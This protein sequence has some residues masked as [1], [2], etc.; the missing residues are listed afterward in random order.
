MASE[1]NG[2]ATAR[3]EG[4]SAVFAVLRQLLRPYE[5]EL[6]IRIDKPGNCYLETHSSSMNGRPMF[7]AGRKNQ[8]KLRQF[9]S[10]RLIY[11]SR[12]GRSNFPFSEEN[13]AGTGLL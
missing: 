12:S 8:E 2:A 1:N 7:F 10:S 11:V 9:L 4:H 6:A 13:N 3:A 5:S